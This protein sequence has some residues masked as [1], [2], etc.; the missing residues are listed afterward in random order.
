M[1]P[2]VTPTEAPITI[3]TNIK[4]EFASDNS[5]Q[6]E[7]IFIPD[8]GGNHTKDSGQSSSDGSLHMNTS[9]DTPGL[10]DLYLKPQYHLSKHLQTNIVSGDNSFVISD[11]F[12]SGDLN[13]DDMVNA[14]DFAIFAA[15]YGSSGVGDLNVD[16][17]INAIDFAIFRNNYGNSGVYLDNIGTN[18]LW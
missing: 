17:N 5:A 7:T 11:N 18:W 8:G 16:G 12:S 15:N 14:I 6:V 1:T 9:L 4:L 13:N 2:T 10:Y 3:T